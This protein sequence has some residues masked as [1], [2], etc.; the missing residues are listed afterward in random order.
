MSYGFTVKAKSKQGLKEAA[1]VEIAKVVSVQPVHAK[2]NLA[3]IKTCNAFADY[4]EHDLD[5]DESYQLTANGYLSW[6]GE[7]GIHTARIEVHTS[8]IKDA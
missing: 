6:N 5:D 8:V 3:I 2:D 4:I 7:G 1:A